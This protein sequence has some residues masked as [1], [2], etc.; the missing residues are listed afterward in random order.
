[1]VVSVDLPDA[2]EDSGEQLVTLPAKVL[3]YAAGVASERQPG[4]WLSSYRYEEALRRALEYLV[5]AD[6]ELSAQSLEHQHRTAPDSP[7]DF[8]LNLGGHRLIIE[9]KTSASG[10]VSRQVIDQL[11]AYLSG[12]DDTAGLLVTNADLSIEA[13][14]RIQEALHEGYDIRAILW[15]SPDDNPELGRAIR[16]L[17]SAA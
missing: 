15:R 6:A 2:E 3:E 12:S 9:A 13:R 10:W 11:L 16:E 14:K 5:Q 17:L 4:A 8:A 1:V 7:A